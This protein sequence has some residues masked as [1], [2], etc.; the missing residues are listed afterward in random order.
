[1]IN[2]MGGGGSGLDAMMQGVGGVGAGTARAG[3]TGCKI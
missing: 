3:T 1:M 2:A